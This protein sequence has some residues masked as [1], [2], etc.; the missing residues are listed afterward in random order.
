MV[1]LVQ[2]R[3]TVWV[4]REE[5]INA[6]SLKSN[7]NCLQITFSTWDPM[8][9]QFEKSCRVAYKSTLSSSWEMDGGKIVA[10]RK[11]EMI[12]WNQFKICR[13]H[14]TPWLLAQHAKALSFFSHVLKNLIHWRFL[15]RLTSSEACGGRCQSRRDISLWHSSVNIILSTPAFDVQL[16]IFVFSPAQLYNC[17]RGCGQLRLY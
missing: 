16:L 4:I 1:W 11:C 6:E 2:T 3:K 13:A 15:N 9:H 10:I 17:T 5:T 7:C 14:Q 12:F 8:R